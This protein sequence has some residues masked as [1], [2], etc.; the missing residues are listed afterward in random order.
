MYNKIIAGIAN[1]ENAVMMIT[2]ATMNEYLNSLPPQ[3]KPLNFKAN[4]RIG[5]INRLAI[6]I[7]MIVIISFVNVISPALASIAND[8]QNNPFAGVGKPQNS[9]CCVSSMLNLANRRAENA[10]MINMI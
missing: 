4:I 3:P 10:T 7:E 2:H 6:I 1:F 5:L 9:V 8:K